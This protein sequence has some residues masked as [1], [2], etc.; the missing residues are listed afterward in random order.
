MAIPPCGTFDYTFVVPEA[1]TAEPW[2]ALPGKRP[3]PR[4]DSLIDDR[5]VGWQPRIA[6]AA[7]SFQLTATDCDAT[8]EL[9]VDPRL[10][11]AIQPGD[12][13]HLT[14]TACGGT[15]LSL[16]RD[17]RLVVAAGAIRSVPLGK[18]YKVEVPENLIRKAAAV[19]AKIDPDYYCRERPLLIRGDGLVRL[20]N[21]GYQCEHGSYYIRVE[22]T[23]KAGIPGTDECVSITD[24]AICPKA[25]GVL[26]AQKI[27]GRHHRS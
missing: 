15:G 2:Q 7:S 23:A 25:G 27:Q 10:L 16:L 20:V 8:L 1:G 9:G 13:L 19:F 5:L 11:A 14:G 26:T 12:R 4:G 18:P 3:K 22:S 17:G 24:T 21:D 6:V